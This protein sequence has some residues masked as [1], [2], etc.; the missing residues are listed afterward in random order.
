MGP[1]QRP[2]LPSPAPE[3]LPLGQVGGGEAPQP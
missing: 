3:A 1:Q 2:R